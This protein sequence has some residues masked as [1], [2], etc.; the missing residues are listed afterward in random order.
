MRNTSTRKHQSRV[1]RGFSSSTVVGSGILLSI[2]SEMNRT[3][4]RHIAPGEH[5]SQS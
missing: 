1:S 4:E 5:V 3:F 2:C